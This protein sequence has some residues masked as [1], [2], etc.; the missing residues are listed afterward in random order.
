MKP[1]W[2]SVSAR[3]NLALSQEPLHLN[4][5]HDR[6]TAQLRFDILSTRIW[7]PLKPILA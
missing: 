1:F 3:R 7:S 4:V 2:M 5:L 6:R